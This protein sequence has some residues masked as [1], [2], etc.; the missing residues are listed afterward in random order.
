MFRVFLAF[1]AMTVL[2]FGTS[3]AEA[4]RFPEILAPPVGSWPEGGQFV[5]LLCTEG[6]GSDACGDKETTPAQRRAID[7]VLRRLPRIK[8]LHYKSKKEALDEMLE[9]SPDLIG[10]ID[11]K[12]MTDTFSGRLHRWS[13]APAV[14]SAIKALPG[15]AF[16][17]VIPT[18][19]WED[20]ADVNIV[21][22]SNTSE[23]EPCKG[24][25]K[26]TAGERAAI[27]TLLRSM[28]GVRRIYFADQAHNMW[29]SKKVEALVSRVR[30]PGPQ[31]RGD[32]AKSRPLDGYYE[33]YYVKLDDPALIPSIMDRVEGMP[34]TWGG[35]EVSVLD[36]LGI[37]S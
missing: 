19:F 21:L 26:A 29:V 37:W 18:P 28:K 9:D 34:G 10:I 35:V 32:D 17:K 15:I 27:E 5:I 23:A 24:R 14:N 7:Q 3:A 31:S 30:N 4:D 16:F 22:C 1:A 25:G 13:D 11:E 33:N 36:G 8:D 12:D 2:L 6:S 20:K